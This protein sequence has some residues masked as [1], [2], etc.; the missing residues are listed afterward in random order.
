MDFNEQ[1]QT[2]M[3][4]KKPCIQIRTNLEKEVF[5]V[6][7]NTLSS[8]NIDNIYRI[9]E[10][11]RVQKITVTNKGKIVTQMVENDNGPVM[12][13]PVVL[14][15]WTRE[16]LNDENNTETHAFIFCDYDYTFDRPTFRRWIKDIFEF[17]NDKYIPFFFISSEPSIPVDLEH[18]FSVVYYDNPTYD[19]VI[20]LLKTY[21]QIKKVEIDDIETLANKF[22]GFNRTEIIECLDYSFFKYNKVDTSYINIKRIEVIKKSNVLDYKEPKF[23]MNDLA[24]NEEFK[25]WYE[26]TKLAFDPD[27][28]KYGIPMPKGYLAIGPAGQ[29]KSCSAEA[30][31]SDLNCPMLILNMSM[32]LSKYV[33]QSE[34]QID[35]AIALIKQVAPCVLLIDEVEKN[36]GGKQLSRSCS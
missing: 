4:I 22:V 6:L 33:G 18:L 12:Y 15:E 30:I 34:Q 23:T 21:K 27:A 28:R 14:L 36:L 25:R 7:L 8:N 31:A 9:D 2:L 35:Q 24:G 11:D 29:A 5:P 17:A 10:L 19:E 20:K 13:N 3:A 16:L 1:I 32:I 26:E